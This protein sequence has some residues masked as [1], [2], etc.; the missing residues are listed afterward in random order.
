MRR[1][2]LILGFVLSGAP[3]IAESVVATRTIRSQTIISAADL[4]LV[5][6]VIPGALQDVNAAI[7]MEARV[8]LYAG[9][10]ILTS[11]IAPAALVERNQIVPLLFRRGGL[12][13]STEGR[14]LT[15]A[16]V[17]D[18]I[19]VMNLQSRSTVNG[20][21]RADGAVVVGMGAP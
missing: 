1:L 16:G 4:S 13:I 6:K 10:P 21:V 11:D 8:N 3:L 19:S 18:R 15:R 20:V 14:A 5:Q 17:G 7:G 9:R 2:I 12:T